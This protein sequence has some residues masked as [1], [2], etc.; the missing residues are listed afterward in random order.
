MQSESG[1][2]TEELEITRLI[3][4]R[5]RREESLE[6]EDRETV[7]YRIAEIMATARQMY[8]TN[9]PR[10][11]NVSGESDLSMDDDLEGLR[12]AFLHLRDLLHDFDATYFESMHHEPPAYDYDGEQAEEDEFAENIDPE[13]E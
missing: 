12:V 13:D 5:L 6:A 2:P 3:F 11:T 8:T 10:L 1:L 4:E 9:L 7:A